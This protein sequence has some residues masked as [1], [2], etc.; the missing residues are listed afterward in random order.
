MTIPI[1]AIWQPLVSTGTSHAVR[2]QAFPQTA[3]ALS[4]YDGNLAA[5]TYTTPAAL[6]AAV[7]TAVQQ[8][9]RSGGA[10]Y[11][12]DDDG[13]SSCEWSGDHFRIGLD[14]SGESTGLE[15]RW[16]ATSATQA[17]GTALGFGTS[18][19]SVFTVTS[20]SFT[21]TAAAVPANWWSPG[22]PA[23]SDSLDRTQH[24][25]TVVRTPSANRLVDW[26]SVQTREVRFEHVEPARI[27]TAD[28]DTPTGTALQRLISDPVRCAGFRYYPDRDSATGSAEYYL[29][30]ESVRAFAPERMPYNS[31]RLYAVTLRMGRKP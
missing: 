13:G 21:F 17:L 8:A 24:A 9:S 15:I 7:R 14:T 11:G 22:L 28:E 3:P 19:V 2:F 18:T 1:P 4:V 30:E 25:R 31:P 5:G 27:Y 16:G 26:Y 6:A 29:L 20:I 12:S 10:T 23:A